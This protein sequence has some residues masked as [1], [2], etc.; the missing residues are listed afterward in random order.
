MVRIAHFSDIHVTADPSGVRFTDLLSKRFAGWLNLRLFRR[1]MRFR[2]ALSVLRA[3]VVDVAA[4]ETDL[5]VFTGDVTSLSLKQEYSRAATI[6]G[7]LVE[8]PTVLGIPGNHDVYVAADAHGAA[9]RRHFGSW[10]RSDIADR[11]TSESGGYP[12]VRFVGEG[13]A[14]VALQSARPRPLWDSS[15]AVGK[16]QLE[17]LRSTLQHPRVRDRRKLLCVHYAPRRPDGSSDSYLHGLRD[18]NRL[19]E[20]AAIGGVALI[21]HGH[22]HKRFV[23]PRGAAAPVHLACVGSLTDARRD[24]S[25]HVYEIGPGGIAVH[26]RRYNPEREVFQAVPEATVTLELA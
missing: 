5:M 2:D 12:I 9:F 17:A 24:R 20:E 21:V 25:Y 11:R 18:A 8:S 10:E 14:A 13:I 16:R 15:G 26:V 6:L 4:Q 22:L 23:C 3:F 1:H 7:S 19:L